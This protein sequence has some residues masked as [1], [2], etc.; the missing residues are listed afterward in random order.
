MKRLIC[1]SLICLLFSLSV[2]GCSDDQSKNEL[3][4]DIDRYVKIV[5]EVHADPWRLISEEAFRE[6]AEELKQRIKGLKEDQLS[7]F[8]QY[9]YLQELAAAIQ[10]G[11]TK[12]YLPDQ[13]FAGTEMIFPYTLKVIDDK[14][15]VTKKW[16]ED[17]LPLYCEVLTINQNPIQDYRKKCDMLANTSLVHA[18]DLMFE[19]AFPYLLET[20]YKEE[21]PWE[22]S[23]KLNGEEKTIEVNGTSMEEYMPKAS[24]RNTQYREYSFMVNDIEVPVLDI[25]SFS[26]GVASDYN[27]FIDNFFE[28]HKE[29][30]YLVIDLRENPGGNGMWGRYLLDCLT[31]EPYMETKEFT[32]KVSQE[33]RRSGYTD[34]AGDLLAVTENGE[35]LTVK[36]DSVRDPHEN[37]GRF[38][39][40]VFCLISEKTF[41]A[42]VVTAAA[43]KSSKMG[44]T[45]GRETSGRIKLCSDP[46][47]ITLPKTQLVAKI[48]LAIFELPGGDP[49]RGVV[50]DY[51]IQYKLD[52]YRT[53]RDLEIE[54]VKDLISKGGSVR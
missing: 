47:N 42:G 13:Y 30:D 20:F 44:I 24:E 39:G 16:G 26:H 31:D 27:I 29:S 48:P 34:K 37:S 51:Q 18:R 5:D 8:D 9:F 2:I 41:S 43:F 54:K 10:D 50:P 19:K 21:P 49:D 7:T 25:P 33:M 23:Y 22:V 12:I 28:E 36:K 45:I 38:A 1:Y 52:D 35:Y 53:G 32:F 40:Q 17:Q 11:H 6:K 14:Y 15:F 46:M 3:I 4:E